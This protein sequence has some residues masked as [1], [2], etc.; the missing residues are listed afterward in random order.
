MTFKKL[1][2]M[3]NT[4]LTASTFSIS[5]AGPGMLSF[6]RTEKYCTKFADEV[7]KLRTEKALMDF[8]IHVKDDEF[9]CAKFVMAAHSPML[10]SLLASDMAEVA[11]QEIR[12]DHI[13][14]DII[15]II[16]DY[17][18]CEDVSFH[19]D[20]LMDIIA[21]ADYLQMTELKQ[22]GLDEVPDILESGN[23]ISWW[24]EAAK[25]N[26]D[27]I[28]DQCEEMMA[29]NF[30]QISRQADFLNLDFIEVQ[31]YVTDIC[32]NTVNSDD[33]V[34]AIMQW[35]SQNEERSPYLEDLLNKVK[36]NKCSAEGIEAI[37]KTHE[38][39]LDKAPTTVYKLLLSTM[40]KIATST[41]KVSTDI[42]VLYM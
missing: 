14:K 4:I 33:I 22:M 34:D 42:I 19:K 5:M 23:V 12:L 1:V 40:V 37:M 39:L 2:C 6:S 31:H 10:R 15:H 30:N 13:C 9:P 25:M 21:A 27:N 20:Q 36:L 16:L 41:P 35:V 11:K 3:K 28:K 26:Y 29:A 7:T 18:Y 32:S 17:M 38:S 24:K 8:K